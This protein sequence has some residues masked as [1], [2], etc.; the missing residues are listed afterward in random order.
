MK[1]LLFVFCFIVFNASTC[2]MDGDKVPP[3]DAF[4]FVENNSSM[5]ILFVLSFDNDTLLKEFRFLKDNVQMELATILAYKKSKDIGC[6]KEFL[7]KGGIYN[8]FLFDKQTVI[9]QPWD[10]IVKN[11]MIL[12]RYDLSLED[13]N[14]MNWTITYP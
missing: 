5:D 1:N 8:L 4:L 3:D 10:T 13:L 11:N 14:S 7:L 9:E 6:E 2:V 12:K